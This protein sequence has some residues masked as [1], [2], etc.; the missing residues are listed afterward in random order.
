MDA[1]D[2]RRGWRFGRAARRP[3]RQWS[4]GRRVAIDARPAAFDRAER[5]LAAGDAETNCYLTSETLAGLTAGDLSVEQAID[6]GR[7]VVIG[8]PFS[9]TR[10]IRLFGN[11]ASRGR[12]VEMFT[13]Y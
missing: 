12:R 3:E 4:G 7:L 10:L 6:S 5:G 13:K 8:R 11:L 1:R 9:I 2:R